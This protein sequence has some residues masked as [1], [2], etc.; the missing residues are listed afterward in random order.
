M[1][2]FIRK[3]GRKLKSIAD[4]ESGS[5]IGDGDERKV[6]S[7]AASAA[8]N[9]A[10][11]AVG[12]VAAE[13]FE[14]SAEKPTE[15]FA[16][17]AT[18]NAADSSDS[19]I[20]ENTADR[21]DKGLIAEISQ[22]KSLQGKASSEKAAANSE[23]RRIFSGAAILGAG[24]FLAKLLG[25]LYRIPLTALLGGAGIGLYQL[26]FP[27]YTVLL[28]FS[29]AGAPSA[30]SKL[31]AGG[32]L[33]QKERRAHGYLTVG[34]KL[35]ASLGAIFS[36]FMFV[37]SKT[38]AR[39][40]GD[41]NAFLSYAAIAPAVFLV[42][43]ITPFRG[44][45]QGLM[46]MKPTAVSQI[47]EQLFKLVF[48][49]LFVRLFMPN[50]PLA[51]AGAA[52]AITVSEGAAALY[53][54]FAYKRRK[55]RLGLRFALE[56]TE[57]FPLAKKLIKTAVPITLVGVILPLS[58]VADSFI[59]VNFLSAYRSD[60]TAL[61]G[62]FSGVATTIVGLPVAVCYGVA[63]VAIPAVSGAND[64]ES[65][66][67][68]SKRTI[69]LTLALS[70]P[71][72]V[73]L[74]LFAPNIIN[75]LFRSLSEE[76]RGISATLLKILSPAAVLLSLLQT[77]NAV[78]IAKN[79]LYAPVLSMAIGAAAKILT[80]IALVKNPTF[81]VYGC[82]VAVIACYFIADL[83]NFIALKREYAPKTAAHGLLNA[84]KADTN[85]KNYRTE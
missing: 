29:G 84:D 19:S 82:G 16:T 73:A 11:N 61:Y 23:R 18:T 83:V 53:L 43:L 3:N 44:Y 17:N 66:R 25:A 69:L 63:A 65:K 55:N 30:L 34:L 51:A 76:E 10:V 31:I 8:A 5:L 45:F 26:V 27:A 47:T 9:V 28:D 79:R 13:T 41:E 72:A 80:E 78:L 48:G 14:N 71:C 70:L 85:R 75:I 35:F 7:T 57:V 1:P 38:L 67:K 49:L 77:Q 21:S 46:N 60:A 54:Y 33:E 52:L 24:T 39:A 4:G 64:K 74:Y 50:V 59:V 56:K 42:C 12:N 32:E 15:S 2:F 62:L 37:F 22:T 58:A 36:L 81:N 20:A 40:Q 6:E 68:N